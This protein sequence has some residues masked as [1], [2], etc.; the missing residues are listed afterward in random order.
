M[1]R[2]DIRQNQ[3]HQHTFRSEQAEL[4][5]AISTAECDES[6]LRQSFDTLSSRVQS[7]QERQ[8]RLFVQQSSANQACARIDEEVRRHT[9]TLAECAQRVAAIAEHA[10][11]KTKERIAVVTQVQRMQSE[12]HESVVGQMMLLVCVCLCSYIVAS[13]AV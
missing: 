4:L 2:E 12:L 6:D 7:L 11:Q 3:M 13:V 9:T 8:R 1:L 5:S 10:I